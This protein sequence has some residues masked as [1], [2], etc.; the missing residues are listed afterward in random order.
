MQVGYLECMKMPM[1]YSIGG[2]N[3]EGKSNLQFIV[4]LDFTTDNTCFR[5]VA[6]ETLRELRGAGSK[7]KWNRTKRKQSNSV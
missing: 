4:V 1:G 2:V 7:D 6:K 5:K 3:N